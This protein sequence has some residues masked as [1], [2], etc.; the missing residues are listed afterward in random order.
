MNHHDG[1]GY[2]GST[3]RAA[4]LIFLLLCLTLPPSAE[5]QAVSADATR[6]DRPLTCFFFWWNKWVQQEDVCVCQTM[7]TSLFFLLGQWC[8]GGCGQSRRERQVLLNSRR[9]AGLGCCSGGPVC[10]SWRI[11]EALS[12]VERSRI[13][14]ITRPRLRFDCWK[15]TPASSSSSSSSCFW[16]WMETYWTILFE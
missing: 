15:Q 1:E 4:Q 6:T 7:I 9:A 16:S 14:K 11:A 13:W 5:G 3:V 10:G 2:Y 12:G 8:D